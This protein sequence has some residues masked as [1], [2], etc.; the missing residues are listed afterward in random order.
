MVLQ[1]IRD[2]DDPVSTSILQGAPSTLIV[3]NFFFLRLL[4]ACP[5]TDSARY[6]SFVIVK[7]SS[8]L[9]VVLKGVFLTNGVLTEGI[10][11]G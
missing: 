10:I 6:L 7:Q 8:L 9:F 3:R 1:D 11:V 5:N 4:S 2:I